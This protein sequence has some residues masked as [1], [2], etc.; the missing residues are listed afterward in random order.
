MLTRG[1]LKVNGVK[2]LPCNVY[3]K[4]ASNGEY[5]AYVFS[6]GSS[7]P[8]SAA[9]LGA[10]LRTYDKEAGTG[11][12]NHM[13]CSSPE[14]DAALVTAMSEFDPDKRNELLAEATRIVFAE[15]PLVPLYWQKIHWAMKD[16]LTIGIGLSEDTL[17]QNVSTAQ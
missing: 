12:F 3:S 9:N 2:V 4:A 17:P 11:A 6:L 16:N 7:T 8:T 14:F 13:R 10:L 1:G 15:T 5:G